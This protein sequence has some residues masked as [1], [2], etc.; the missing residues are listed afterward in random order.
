MSKTYG[1][2]GAEFISSA[3]FMR[4]I[5]PILEKITR[6]PDAYI[7]VSD[8]PGD[9]GTFVS[10][11]LKEIYY[12]NAIVYHIGNNPRSNIA[13]LSTKSFP[14]SDALYRTLKIDS[15]TVIEM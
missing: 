5:V 13:V 4:E 2:I 7:I 12:R 1:F 15:H 10:R 3:R 6:D 8:L 9:G 11:Y 14:D